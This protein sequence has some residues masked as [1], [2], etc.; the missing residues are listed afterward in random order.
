VFDHVTIRASDLDRSRRFYETVAPVLGIR[1]RKDEPDWVA[2]RGEAG[3]CSFVSSD[4]PSEH[5]HLAVAV[6]DNAT[7]EEFHRVALAAGYRDNGGPPGAGRLPPWLLRGL[8]ARSR[9]P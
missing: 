3:S 7:V 9:R 4:Q 8:R 2:F 5:V 6:S 1:L